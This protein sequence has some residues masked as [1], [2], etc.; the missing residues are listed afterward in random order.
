M[1]AIPPDYEDMKA[2]PSP[3]Y[4]AMMRGEITSEE[5]VESLKR[6][7]NRRLAAQDARL[8]AQAPE[9][10]K[11]VKV[12]GTTAARIYATLERTART[13]VQGFLGIVTADALNGGLDATLLDSLQVGALAG[14]YAILMAFAFPPRYSAAPE[15]EK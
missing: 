1:S 8:A 5:Y 12:K 15:E 4:L 7:V 11:E 9:T 3:E 13:F 14:V 2:A 6:R 10:R